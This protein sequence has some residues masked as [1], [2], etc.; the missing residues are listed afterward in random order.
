[1]SAKNVTLKVEN[2]NKNYGSVV[3]LSNVSFEILKGEVVALVGDNG[4]GKSTLVKCVAGSVFPS[5]GSIYLDGEKV[6]FHTPGQARDAGIET[7]YQ[8]L[9]LVDTFNISE[10]LFLGKEVKRTGLSR[11]FGILDRKEMRRQALQAIQEFNATFPDVN[12]TV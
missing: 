12:A 7:V 4:A 2:L 6:N 9:A 3:A 5:S 11:L 8:Q 10:N 1:M